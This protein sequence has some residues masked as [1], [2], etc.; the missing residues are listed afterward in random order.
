MRYIYKSLFLIYVIIYFSMHGLVSYGEILVTMLI[1]AVNIYKERL[2]DSAALVIISF[3][4]ICTAVHYN[5]SLGILFGITAFDLVT[6]RMYVG[7]IPL[8]AAIP[9][10]LL[11]KPNFVLIV[12]IAI[13]SGLFA[14]VIQYSEVKEKKYKAILDE[15]RRLRYELE[16]AKMKLLNSTRDIAYLAE[17]RERNRI[18]RDIHDNIGH[19][20][21]GIL[22]Q[23]QAAYKLFDR[24]GQKSKGIMKKSIDSLAEAV[25]L[26]RDT[27]HNIKPREILGAE[28]IKSI[29]DEFGFCPIDFQFSG[30][31]GSISPNYMEILA[32]NI[33]EALTNASKHS[34]ASS[35]NIKIDINEK[36]VRLY[37]KDNGVGC[38][39]MK[40]GLGISGMKERAANVGGTISLDSSDGFMIVC[41][42][43]AEIGEGG[44]FNE[45]SHS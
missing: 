45:S 5:D 33:K 10:F 41:L 28:Y 24:D 12:M 16:T 31:F 25:T 1:A 7:L 27:V 8:T 22:I 2:Y 17:V 4:L 44:L 20:I 40:E 30:D 38:S 13:V 32:T 29:I 14:Y 19:S 21:A 42:M 23:L 3:G 6:K 43:P 26:L 15:E 11:D 39:K 34:K 35:V 18:A 36:F 37:I 9:Y